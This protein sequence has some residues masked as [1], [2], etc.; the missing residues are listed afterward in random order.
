MAHNAS[1][2]NLNFDYVAKWPRSARWVLLLMTFLVVILLG[3]GLDI[4]DQKQNLRYLASHEQ[5]LHYQLQ[6]VQN[7]LDHELVKSDELVQ[8]RLQFS[9]L[10][11][12]L[13]KKNHLEKNIA[14]LSALSKRVG[15]QL[16]SIKSSPERHHDYLASKLIKI[17]VVGDYTHLATFIEKMD[18]LDFPV[19]FSELNMSPEKSGWRMQISAELYRHNVW[20]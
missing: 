6:G 15:V 14:Q 1:W 5:T 7:S 20:R 13:P 3:Y 16:V 4:E 9:Q 10:V 18:G 12:A 17:T 11:G 8:S 2:R 19:R